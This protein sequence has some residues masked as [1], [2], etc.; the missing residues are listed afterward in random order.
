V[1]L[2]VG[3]ELLGFCDKTFIKTCPVLESYDVVTASNLERKV[4]VI[5]NIM[6]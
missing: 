6:D 2:T 5:E 1:E 4:R 3:D